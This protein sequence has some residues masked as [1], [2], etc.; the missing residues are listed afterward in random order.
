MDVSYHGQRDA[1][2]GLLSPPASCL[3][4]LP[5]R[6]LTYLRMKHWR[7]QLVIL[8]FGNVDVS[9]CVSLQ[10]VSAG[11]STHAGISG[12]L[13]L[14]LLGP[15]LE[16]VHPRYV[17]V[18]ASRDLRYLQRAS[19]SA[20]ASSVTTPTTLPTSTP[21]STNCDCR[22]LR[23]HAKVDPDEDVWRIVCPQLEQL[24]G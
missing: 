22:H 2:G 9:D 20:C 13:L 4:C 11:L 8:C 19:G 12:L 24:L 7:I 18:L 1:G 17:T 6:H 15:E 23:A 3:S 10:R 5:R 21:E 16:A 14:Q